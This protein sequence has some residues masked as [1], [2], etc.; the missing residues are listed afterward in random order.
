MLSVV[1]PQWKLTNE[2]GK[3]LWQLSFP[4]PPPA[5]CIFESTLFSNDITLFK[6]LFYRVI[7]FIFNCGD[8][9]FTF[10]TVLLCYSWLKNRNKNI[11]IFANVSYAKN[12]K[13]YCFHNGQDNIKQICDMT[14]ISF[15]IDC[16]FNLFLLSIK[17]IR[18]QAEWRIWFGNNVNNWTTY[19]RATAMLGT[20]YLLNLVYGSYRVENYLLILD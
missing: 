16:L 6:L 7:S 10:G 8:L 9:Y 15:Q 20:L 17:E 19:K 14:W 1:H 13:H 3:T 5:H 2:Y 18:D 11:K 4:T 12:D